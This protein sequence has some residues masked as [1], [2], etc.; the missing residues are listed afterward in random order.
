VGARTAGHLHGAQ[1]VPGSIP[2]S[3]TENVAFV[4]APA[5]DRPR[6]LV[7]ERTTREKMAAMA[8]IRKMIDDMTKGR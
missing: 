1:E 7:N 6:A 8:A 3:S 4:A 2:V 5:P